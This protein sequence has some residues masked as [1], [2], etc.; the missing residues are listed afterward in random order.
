VRT[1]SV[2]DGLT[3]NITEAATKDRKKPCFLVPFERDPNFVPHGEIIETIALKFE[4][5]SRLALVGLGG[6]GYCTFSIN[7]NMR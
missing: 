6:V 4:T 3:K 1:Q 7:S 5:H 2:V